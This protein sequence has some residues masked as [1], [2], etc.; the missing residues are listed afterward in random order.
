L[1]TVT[2]APKSGG[3]S[4]GVCQP[5]AY[6]AAHAAPVSA[7][8]RLVLSA[9]PSAAAPTVSRTAR[10]A[11]VRRLDAVGMAA[12]GGRPPA[13]AGGYWTMAST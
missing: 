7:G 9:T 1:V 8:A 5:T 13:R 2:V 10:A 6:T 12:P 11:L 3:L 4:D